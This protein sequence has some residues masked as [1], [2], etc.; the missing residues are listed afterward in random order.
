M[1]KNVTNYWNTF[2]FGFFLIIFCAFLILSL[3]FKFHDPLTTLWV[4]LLMLGILLVCGSTFRPQESKRTDDSEKPNAETT[5]PDDENVVKFYL[6]NQE[7]IRYHGERMWDSMKVF[8]IVFPSIS[9]VVTVITNFI[10]SQDPSPSLPFGKEISFLFLIPITFTAIFWFN[11]YRE[12]LRFLEYSLMSWNAEKKLNFHEPLPVLKNDSLVI[13]R[14]LKKPSLKP[15]FGLSFWTTLCLFFGSS[16]I[17]QA[18]LM[19]YI[20]AII[21]PL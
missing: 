3:H 20:Y 17:I 1:L 5:M 13:D 10:L 18:V 16:V 21:P 15:K 2:L 11:S 9:G 8:G 19:S 4:G 6:N 7:C 14:F 12:Y